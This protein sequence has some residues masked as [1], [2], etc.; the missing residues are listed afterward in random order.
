M[1]IHIDLA[2][3]FL[4]IYP[5]AILKNVGGKKQRR[6]KKENRMCKDVHCKII[7]SS[8]KNPCNNLNI[9]Q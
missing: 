7:Y 6:I 8:K 1:N 9:H 5:L 2:I 3:T 4:G